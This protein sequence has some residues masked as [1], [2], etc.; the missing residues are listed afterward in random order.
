M[1]TEKYLRMDKLPHIWC[2]GCGH[3]TILNSFIRAFSESDL[4]QDK[5][6]VISGIGC[7]G[8]ATGYLNFDTLHTTHGRAIAFATGVKMANPNLN[9]IVMTGDG[10]GT[11]IGG[12]HLIHAA[13]RNI[14]L[15]VILFNNQIYGMT[16]GQFSPMTPPSDMATT[17][18]YGNIDQNFDLA[19]LVEGAGGTFIAR[20]ATFDPR[21]LKRLYLAALKHK[22]F[23]FVES[24]SQCPVSY[25][26]QN[27]S[28]DAVEM[29][30]SQKKNTVDFKKWQQLSTEK[31]QLL[32]PLGI[33]KEVDSP[34]S[35]Y[36]VR[37]KKI[38][39]KANQEGAL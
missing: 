16:G 9:V 21:Q 11:A 35:E 25:G 2:P 10:D 24:F 38:I 34:E 20:G 28:G 14:D 17:A 36:T 26:R 1:E 4:D 8:R 31:K 23:S 3:G 32:Y 18:P 37:Y 15:T 22:G 30:K 33:L 5:T 6:V 12:N 7:S 19:Q 27:G 29:L 13:R 39:A